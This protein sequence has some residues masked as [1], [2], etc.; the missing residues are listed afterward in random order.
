MIDAKA[1]CL[2]LSILA[3]C[4]GCGPKAPTPSDQHQ[5]VTQ[6]VQADKQF[7][8]QV[9]ALP[10]DQR[11]TFLQAHFMQFRHLMNDP[12]PTVKAAFVQFSQQK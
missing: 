5:A 10:P 3:A 1:W 8:A 11:Q 7:I 4:I 12:D 2:T 9:N 6:M